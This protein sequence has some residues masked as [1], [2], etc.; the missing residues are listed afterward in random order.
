MTLGLKHPREDWKPPQNPFLKYVYRRTHFYQK[1]WIQ[2]V[3]GTPGSGKSYCCLSMGYRLDPHFD[4]SNVFF[5]P[6]TFLEGLNSIKRNG[7][8]LFY[9]E[10]E[11]SLSNK[12]WQSI[13]NM[14]TTDVVNICRFKKPIIFFA[15][16]EFTRMDKS[17]RLAVNS[18][19]WASRKGNDAV[20]LDVKKV[21]TQKTRDDVAFSSF[22]TTIDKRKYKIGSLIFDKL[23]PKDLLVAYEKEM[24]KMK[25]GLLKRRAKELREL[26]NEEGYDGGESL[27]DIVEK[28]LKDPE[29]YKSEH[30]GTL[31]KQLIRIEFNISHADAEAIKVLVEKK[32]RLARE[33]QD[34]E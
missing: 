19:S 7:T 3:T 27:T 6:S 18:V 15:L 4:I 24:V 14:A 13:Q 33:K 22:R 11:V 34:A 10:P 2:A 17:I 20:R 23:P 26:E 28:V 31:S 25:E 30:R 32:L 1:S 8:V 16:P 29:A 5:K 9:D 12:K 21:L